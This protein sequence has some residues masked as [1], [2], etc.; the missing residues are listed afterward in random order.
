MK[1]C[2]DAGLSVVRA[3]AGFGKS[4]SV[5]E[6]F[7]RYVSAVSRV[8]WLTCDGMSEAM[9][10]EKFCDSIAQAD[11]AAAQKLRA[12]GTLNQLNSRHAVYPV[13]SVNS[14][15]FPSQTWRLSSA[16]HSPRGTVF[17]AA[18]ENSLPASSFTDSSRESS[19]AQ[20]SRMTPPA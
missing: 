4:V 14:V 19:T 16:F 2:F 1:E 13:L 12:F 10:C 7:R 15:Q 6:Y 8:F 20:A 5:E 11:P 17:H 9:Y 18:M 3:P